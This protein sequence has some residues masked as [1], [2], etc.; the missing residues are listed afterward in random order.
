M[1][2]AAHCPA[3]DRW[4]VRSAA[5][6]GGAPAPRNRRTAHPSAE[7]RHTVT[8]RSAP[9]GGGPLGRALCRTVRRTSGTP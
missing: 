2:A 9:F 7:V 6:F 4:D 3:E 8:I 5:L 1:T